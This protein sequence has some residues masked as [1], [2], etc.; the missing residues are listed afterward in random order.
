MVLPS[1]AFATR[2]PLLTF[3]RC[4]VSMHMPRVCLCIHRE[5]SGTGTANGATVCAYARATPCPVLRSHV[6]VPGWYRSSSILNQGV[7]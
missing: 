7:I 3:A 6:L 4:D 5:L 2:C 1:Y